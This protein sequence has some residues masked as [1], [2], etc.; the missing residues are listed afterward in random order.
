MLSGLYVSVYGMMSMHIL[1]MNKS[2]MQ[3][4]LSNIMDLY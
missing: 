4:S 1:N 2:H 3:Y